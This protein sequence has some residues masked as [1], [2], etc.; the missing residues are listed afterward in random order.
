MQKEII[1]HDEEYIY[2]MM[3]ENRKQRHVRNIS[4]REYHE[5]WRG[6]PEGKR[7][8]EETEMYIY[9]KENNETRKIGLLWPSYIWWSVTLMKSCNG[10]I[11]ICWASYLR[12]RKRSVCE[13]M[14]MM[15]RNR[16]E[17]LESIWNCLSMKKPKKEVLLNDRDMKE[18]KW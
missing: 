6:K 11:L 10:N 15:S 9:V 2:N 13:E 3:K 14:T 5:N 4:D 16:R 8:L 7:S 1:S 12:R 18:R 17:S